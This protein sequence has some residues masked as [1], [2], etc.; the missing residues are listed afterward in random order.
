MSPSD[1]AG[2][3]EMAL[4]ASRTLHS[5]M[6]RACR[7]VQCQPQCLVCSDTVYHTTDLG[8]LDHFEHDVIGWYVLQHARINTILVL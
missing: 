3:P 6:P 1:L 8:C 7:L 5:P 4:I 2:N